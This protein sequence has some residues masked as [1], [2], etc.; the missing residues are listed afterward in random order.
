MY[1]QLG[2]EHITSLESLDHILFVVA[3]AI[4]YIF[5]EYKKVLILVT[6]FTIGHSITLALS[7]LQFINFSTN[8][9]E[10]LIPLTIFISSTFNIYYA[11]KNDYNKSKLQI[12]KYLI[13]LS[14]GLIHGLG[15]SFTLRA[16]LGGEGSIVLPLFAFNVG[17]EIA[18]IVIV[19]MILSVS[20]FL[21][22]FIKLKQ[23][24]WIL[25]VSFLTAIV[26]IQMMVSRII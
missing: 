16:L 19:L 17:L 11:K 22:K 21:I 12:S 4:V 9:I 25:T 23:K 3:L 20:T 24:V 18:Q 13:A 10:F 14:F 5:S 7:T 26:S 2:F 6:A 15:F 1:L 8:I